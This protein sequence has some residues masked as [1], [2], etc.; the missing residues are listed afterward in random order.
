[1]DSIE[2]RWDAL[3]ELV[4]KVEKALGLRP[5]KR[6][7]PYLKH[8]SKRAWDA[9]RSSED[10]RTLD[11]DGEYGFTCSHII[12]TVQDIAMMTPDKRLLSFLAAML[13]RK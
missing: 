11:D 12:T 8:V 3:K 1:M 4:S 5:F 10:G 7:R 6:T 9:C 2:E 13:V